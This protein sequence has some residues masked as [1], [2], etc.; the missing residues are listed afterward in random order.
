M[1]NSCTV[2]RREL[3]GGLWRGEEKSHVVQDIRFELKSTI[4]T[5]AATIHIETKSV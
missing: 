3:Y 4:W 5:A 1:Y 2:A